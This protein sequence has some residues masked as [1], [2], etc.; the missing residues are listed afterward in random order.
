MDLALR[1]AATAREA[2]EVPVGA[3]VVDIPTGRLVAKAHNQRELL[4]DSTAHAEMLAITQAT[5]Y[6]ESWRLTRAALFVT[7]EPCLMC[8]GAIIL[9]RIPYVFYGATDPKAGAHASLYHVLENQANNHV[10]AVSGGI[11]AD[12]SARLLSEFFRA[13]RQEGKK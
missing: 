3:V 5:A 6:Y 1:E 11:R 4:R 2:D 7:L 10:P 13:R 8:S 9:S 12:E